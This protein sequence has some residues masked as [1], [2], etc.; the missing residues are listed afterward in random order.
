[1][2]V[3]I[4]SKMVKMYQ[5]TSAK[6]KMQLPSS[7]LQTQIDLLCMFVSTTSLAKTCLIFPLDELFVAR[8][9][10]RPSLEF[11]NPPTDFYS[12]FLERHVSLVYLC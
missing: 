9:E 7:L 12:G 4:M 8:P 10:Q 3:A 6:K 5:I 1:M 2:I 11:T